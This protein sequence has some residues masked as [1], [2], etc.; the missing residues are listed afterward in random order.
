M[1][2]PRRPQG[3]PRWPPYAPRWPPYAPRWPQDGPSGPPGGSRV[4]LRRPKRAPGWPQGGHKRAQDGPKRA[5][6]GLK[7]A[8]RRPQMRSRWPNKGQDSRSCIKK[9]RCQK[10]LKTNGKSMFF[11]RFLRAKSLDNACKVAVWRSCA[12]LGGLKRATWSPCW[13]E[14]WFGR[15]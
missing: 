12:G 7:M 11:G 6:D 15:G 5:Q 3:G 13:L 8:P 2:A 14:D 4:A 10:P 9:A 1:R